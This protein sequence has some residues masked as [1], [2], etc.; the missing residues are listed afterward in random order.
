MIAADKWNHSNIAT[1]H[2]QHELNATRENVM[3]RICITTHF[4]E[5]AQS[6]AHLS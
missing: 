6:Y 5:S 3:Q 2:Q 4:V 1:T